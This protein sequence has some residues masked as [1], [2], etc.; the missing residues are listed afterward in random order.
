MRFD[1][2][3]QAERFIGLL[4][5]K[6]RVDILAALIDGPLR[7]AQLAQR[8]GHEASETSFRRALH[9]LQTDGLVEHRDANYRLTILG[10]AL[11][12]PLGRGADCVR[13]HRSRGDSLG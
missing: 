4:K 13:V 5:T 2:R 11:L 1:Q 3:D 10:Q 12:D 7:F 8:L 6:W 9:G